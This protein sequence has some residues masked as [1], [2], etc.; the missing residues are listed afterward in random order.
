MRLKRPHCSEL[1]GLKIR[2]PK[3]TLLRHFIMQEDDSSTIEEG[4]SVT[5]SSNWDN[6]L[7]TN[8]R[9]TELTDT[10]YR[11]DGWFVTDEDIIDRAVQEFGEETPIVEGIRYLL[12]LVEKQARS[13]QRLKKKRH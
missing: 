6:V 13:I 7:H 4:F 5:E 1:P 10:E 8:N 12:N 3:L 11:R 9:N 2:A